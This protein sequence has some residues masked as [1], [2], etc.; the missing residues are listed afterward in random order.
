MDG[1]S[2]RSV[3]IFIELKKYF[4]I[5]LITYP[6]EQLERNKKFKKRSFIKSS[7]LVNDIN[8]FQRIITKKLP[9]FS[10]HDVPAIS[11]GID[12]IIKQRGPFDYI[13]F[14]TQLMAQVLLY[15]NWN[16]PK[17]IDLYDIY[18]S[19]IKKKLNIQESYHHITLYFIMNSKKLKNTR[20]SIQEGRYFNCNFKN[21]SKYII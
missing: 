8:L 16:I 18:S 7:F 10:S 17:I 2:V 20:K 19:V 11:S 15:K 3:N 21:R 12:K 1:G 14:A 9:G 4:D 13:Y 5:F 6:N